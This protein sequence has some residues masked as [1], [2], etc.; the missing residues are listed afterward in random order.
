MVMAKFITIYEASDHIVVV[1][2]MSEFNKDSPAE[3]VHGGITYKRGC[4][5]ELPREYSGHA[6]SCRR[7]DEK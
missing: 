7:Y 1:F 5:E 3:L 6:C 4:L 2:P